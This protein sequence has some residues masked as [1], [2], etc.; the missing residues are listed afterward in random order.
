MLSVTDIQ[1]TVEPILRDTN[2]IRLILFGSYAKETATDNSDIDLFLDSNGEIT[3][4]AFYEIK[5]KIEDALP[6]KIHLLPD[7]DVI[8][9]SAVANQISKSGV[10]VYER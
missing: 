6:A 8:P 2:V 4:L 7:L 5:A 10:V 1:T 9:E 3:G